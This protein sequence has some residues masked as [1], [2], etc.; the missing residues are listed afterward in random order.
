M[1]KYLFMAMAIPCRPV[2]KES[3]C[4]KQ[5][6]EETKLWGMQIKYEY[7]DSN[8]YTRFNDESEF[9]TF[10]NLVRWS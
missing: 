3:S 8:W 7:P 6:R 9:S 5:K 4:Y 1:T 2:K 10:E